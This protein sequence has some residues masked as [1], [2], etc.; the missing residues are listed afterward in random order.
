ML[1]CVPADRVA[2]AVTLLERS[3]EQVFAV[4]QVARRRRARRAGG[5]PHAM[6]VGVLVSGSGTNLQALIDRGTRE[7]ARPGAADRRR[8]QRPRLPGA[9]ARPAGRACRP[10]SST[11]A[12]TPT[13]RLRSRAGRGAARAPG[14]SGGPGRLHARALAASCS[15]PS[16]AGSSTST[17]PSCRPSPACTRSEAGVRGRGQDRRLH[18]PLRRRR[19]RHRP[20]H[21]P[22]RRAGA[23]R[24]RRRGAAGAH[25]GR[26]APP[27]AG[28]GAR[29]RRAAG[30][31][32]R[33]AACASSARRRRT[34]A[35][36]SL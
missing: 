36:R 18:G 4:G 1:V 20:D 9:V 17:P 13:R 7:R 30:G 19:R 35:L 3:G 23:G 16:Q 2:E 29:H 22:G 21:R 11:T 26:G 32:W 31:R 33:G 15:T 14:R 24:R 27:A 5:V 8:L 10:S 6:N 28:G 12:T 25:P 34:D